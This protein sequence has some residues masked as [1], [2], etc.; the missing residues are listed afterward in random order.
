MNLPNLL[1]MALGPTPWLLVGLLLLGSH[2]LIPEPTLVALGFAGIITALVAINVP[3][4]PSQLLVYG[5]AAALLIGLIRGFLPRE[6][7]D[8][9]PAHYGRACDAIAPG[10]TGRVQY[11]GTLWQARCQISDAAIAPDH[12]VVVVAREGNTLIVMPLPTSQSTQP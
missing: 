11:E 9:E 10:T 1:T 7:P 4:F 12:L 5:L 8:L 6:S 3:L 2:L